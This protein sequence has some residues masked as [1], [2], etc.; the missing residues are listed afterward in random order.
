[1]NDISRT[2][3]YADW[4][5]NPVTGCWGPGGTAEKPLWCSYCYARRIAERFRGSKAWPQGF[6][7]MF[8]PERLYEPLRKRKPSKIF[9]CDMA[10]LFGAWVP[11]AHIQEIFT[12]V[13]LA[14]QHTF[15]FLTK[16]P[17][18]LRREFNPWP[19]NA[20][21]GVTATDGEM[22]WSA[23][24]HLKE[25]DAPVKFLS[26]E[27][28][29]ENLDITAEDLRHGGINWVIIG[30]AT[31][32]YRPPKREWLQELE[33]AAHSAGIPVFEKNNLKRLLGPYLRQEHPKV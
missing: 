26:A 10:D 24:I 7:P 12:T 3:G 30:G 33:V 14:P 32:P 13:R 28:L 5:W 25:V 16:N 21:V 18:R 31:Q 23:I 11:S 27:P 20:W 2:I 6:D 19:P 29:L 22:L 9:V 1:M 4:S 8:H 17:A 15:L